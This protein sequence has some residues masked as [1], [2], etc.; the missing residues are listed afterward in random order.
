MIFILWAIATY[1]IASIP[2]SLLIGWLV[3]RKDIRESGDGNPGATNVKRAGGGLPLY[4]VA[5]FLDGFKGLFPV[6]IP[7]WL[8]GW[9]GL[10]IVPI[11]LAAILGHGFSI[12]LRGKGGKA[13]ATTGGIWTGLL[14]FE[15][16]LVIATTLTFWFYAIKEED[17]AV[18]LMMLSLLAYVLYTR[19]ANTP[20]MLIWL[21]NFALVA[22]KH[23]SS[24]S[25]LPTLGR[26]GEI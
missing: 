24:L 9:Q 10:E 19:G 16:A 22:F 26:R 14:G 4:I 15:G 6:G 13:I 18:V 11:A 12:F 21:G 5:L 23:R 1:F 25:S 17:W 8:M 2:F 20:L 3:L 7:Y